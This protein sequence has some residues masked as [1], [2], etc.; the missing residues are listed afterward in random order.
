MTFLRNL[1][2]KFG[3]VVLAMAVL[4]P[5]GAGADEPFDRTLTVFR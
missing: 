2:L 3:R 5:V 1:V 4:A